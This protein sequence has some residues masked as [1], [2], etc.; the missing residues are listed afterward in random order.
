MKRILFAAVVAVIKASSVAS[1]FSGAPDGYT[2]LAYLESSGAQYIDTGV[3]MSA[4]SGFSIVYRVVAPVSNQ[5][6]CGSRTDSGDTRCMVGSNYA[7]FGD[8]IDTVAYVGWGA[9][10]VPTQKQ[11]E[12]VGIGTVRINYLN[13][14]KVVCRGVSADLSNLPTQD[15]TFYLFAANAHDGILYGSSRI[16]DVRISSGSVCVRHYIPVRRDSDSALGL[17]DTVNE[18][19]LQNGGS[20]AFIAGPAVD[21]SSYERLDY[22]E[23]SG[24]QYVDTGVLFTDRHGYSLTWQEVKDEANSNVCGSRNT[25][26]DTRCVTGANHERVYIGWNELAVSSDQWILTTTEGTAQVNYLNSRKVVVRGHQ[27]DLTTLEP[28][29]VSF[30]LFGAH[31][32]YQGDIFSSS[33]IMSFEMTYD[34]KVVMSLVPARRKTDGVVGFYDELNGDFY[35][36][37]SA[38]ALIEPARVLPEGYAR[39]SYVESTGTQYIN[40]GVKDSSNVEVEI[41]V[42]EAYANSVQIFGARKAFQ[43]EALSLSF[44]SESGSQGFRTC[45]GND[46]IDRLIVADSLGVG[47]G[48]HVF[49]FGGGRCPRIDGAYSVE[50][51]SSQEFANSLDLFAFGLNNNGT[52]H[53]QSSSV[54]IASLRLYDGGELV[55]DFVP[56]LSLSDFK[57]GL[58]DRQNGVFYGNEGTGAFLGGPVVEGM[59]GGDILADK[60]IGT[61]ALDGATAQEVDFDCSKLLGLY[62]LVF[63]CRKTGADVSTVS[64]QLDGRTLGATVTPS[65]SGSVTANF[66][67]KLPQGAHKLSFAGTSAAELSE[68]SLYLL[69]EKLKTGLIVVVP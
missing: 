46:K 51:F 42:Y 21:D 1:V 67:V 34:D 27:A 45:W 53:P 59:E 6:V 12:D 9:M 31:Y 16:Y 35:L 58:Y 54:R 18:G 28:Q 14:G 49:S 36:N 8:Y 23:S 47:D 26:G 25:S 4:D 64:V 19:F 17:Y 39:I 62:R 60:E 24:T 29:T 55:R 30:Y 33:R 66:D 56:M 2:R 22:L 5:A 63:Q 44:Q 65:G 37:E 40:T 68:V 7:H 15:K 43:N 11:I 13:S 61:I 52:L 50:C 38:T 10:V 48:F 20:G 32:G 69:R 3:T 41:S 57:P